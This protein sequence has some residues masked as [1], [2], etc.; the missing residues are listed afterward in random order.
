MHRLPEQSI[1]L[2]F[3]TKALG[4]HAGPSVE[5]TQRGAAS[6]P[7]F[8]PR[9][10]LLT[11]PSNISTPNISPSL[12]IEN[13]F[14]TSGG[15]FGHLGRSSSGK[16]RSRIRL[17]D[18]AYDGPLFGQSSKASGSGGLSGGIGGMQIG[19]RVRRAFSSSTRA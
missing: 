10:T 7:S 9:Q 11:P 4:L 3:W 6:L 14:G 12:S 1:K 5:A 2:D 19:Q 18:P 15:D 8:S 13:T 16:K 17:D